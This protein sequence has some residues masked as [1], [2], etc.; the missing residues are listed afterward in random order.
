M[1]VHRSKFTKL[2]KK[3]LFSL[4]KRFKKNYYVLG[5]RLDWTKCRMKTIH[6]PLSAYLMF[7]L[8]YVVCL[9]VGLF[10]RQY[11]W[12]ICL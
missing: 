9:C 6:Q 8:E 3:I 2:F 10:K 5:Y 4:S 7:V 11:F 12:V 1:K